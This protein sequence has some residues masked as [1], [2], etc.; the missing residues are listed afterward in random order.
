MDPVGIRASVLALEHLEEQLQVGDPPPP[1]GDA[2]PVAPRRGGKP[3]EASPERV[4]RPVD[5][6]EDLRVVGMRLEKAECFVQAQQR[7]GMT[8]H[9]AL[10]L[11]QERALSLLVSGA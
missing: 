2:N 4:E 5:Q 3:L 6:L 8:D 1:L 10:E 9:G 7:R 11:D